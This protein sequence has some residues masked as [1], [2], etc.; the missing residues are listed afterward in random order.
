MDLISDIERDFVNR[1]RDELELLDHGLSE[2]R[3]APN[4]PEKLTYLT[5]ILQSLQEMSGLLAFPE[6]ENLFHSGHT[7]LME[8]RQ[9]SPQPCL[10]AIFE[11]QELIKNGYRRLSEME[12]RTSADQS[13]VHSGDVM[14]SP[15]PRLAQPG[16][17]PSP[18]QR[19][20]SLL[21]P[22]DFSADLLVESLAK[23][24][25]NSSLV[26]AGELTL[27]DD[28]VLE[29]DVE[30]T[31]L[32]RPKSAS[33]VQVAVESVVDSASLPRSFG[34]YQLERE[35][36]RGGMGTVCL[37]TDRLLNRQ[38]ALKLLRV[39][40]EDG[41]EIVERFYRE[42]RSMA[43]LQHANLC[44]IYDFGEVDGQPYLTM[45][46]ING[47]PLSEF[48]VDGRPLATRYAVKLALTLATA[49]H[50][51]HQAGIVHRDLKPA[52]VM[53]NQEGEP[54]LL[55]FGLARR[56]QPD[57]VELSQQG[58]ILGSPAYMAPEQVEGRIDQIGPATDV[59]ALG[60]ILY[61]MLSGQKPFDGTVASVLAQVH[62]KE[63]KRLNIPG[64]FES[65][66]D[67][68]CRR[69]MAKAIPHRY[70]SALEFANV[71]T[72]YLED[73]NRVR[74]MPDVDLTPETKAVGR[75]SANEAVT[76]TTHSW[77]HPE[78]RRR[79]WAFAT[80]AAVIAITVATM[81]WNS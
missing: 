40:P 18:F 49:L 30:S 7:R 13:T 14:A 20:E 73:A 72:K 26:A 36:G 47:R 53:I 77:I 76:R 48:L 71:L 55:D 39:Q 59:H 52:N 29:D 33:V 3:T 80:A 79:H 42:A 57:E 1:S 63:A 10:V 70:A 21:Q 31:V 45:A 23:A 6:L 67:A 27:P 75:V 8:F 37:A 24:A 66:L 60:V 46:Y 62:S 32:L 25:E 35:L 38:V 17:P 56:Q 41:Q 54:I 69:A 2:W 58:M 15:Q 12:F 9:R 19:R 64:D 4:D 43:S 51:A 44:P 65:R 22:A 81:I 34:R 74:L 28:N 11:L 5:E 68:I 50:Q 61:E 16:G 78:R